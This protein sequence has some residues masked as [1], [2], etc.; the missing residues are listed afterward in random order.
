MKKLLS[1]ISAFLLAGAL[2]V[3][4]AEDEDED[5]V[6]TRFTLGGYSGVIDQNAKTITV[7]AEAS[8]TPSISCGSGTSLLTSLGDISSEDSPVLIKVGTKSQ[9]VTYSVIFKTIGDRIDRGT[10]YFTELYN[11]ASFNYK[12]TNNQFVEISNVSDEELDLSDVYLNRH[13]WKEGKRRSDLDQSVPLTGIKLASKKALVI[14]SQRCSWFTEKSTDTAV[15]KSDFSYNG[16]ISFSDQD[17]FTIT[18]KGTV[19]DSLGPNDGAGNGVNWIAEK[20]MQR[21][22]NTYFGN[23]KFDESQWILSY[24]TNADGDA[25]ATAGERLPKKNTTSYKPSEA[26]KCLTYVRFESTNDY[27][28]VEINES[29]H[30]VTVTF[31][32]SGASYIQ[33]PTV[34]HDGNAIFLYKN[35]G[36]YKSLV[37]GETPVDFSEE[38]LQFCVS[39]TDETE[40]LYDITASTDEYNMTSNISG[41][42]QKVAFDEIADGDVILF[43]NPKNESLIGTPSG[44]TLQAVSESLEDTLT[45]MGSMAAFCVNKREEYYVFTFNGK[46]LASTANSSLSLVGVPSDDAKWTISAGSA[47]GTKLIKNK[48]GRAIEYYKS[49]FGSYSG[50]G[51]AYDIV[52]YK[53]LK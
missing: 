53:R 14:Y 34:S 38:G 32:T 52:F 48:S 26:G 8:G 42:Y 5:A 25:K 3:S 41:T 46:F 45:Y 35:G 1:I 16:I 47:D 40:Q 4:C 11:G 24:A 39:S 37:S 18:Y 21:K 31:Y 7:S 44:T 17:T 10:L 51:D 20:Q 23:A 29:K 13:V 43:A 15:F 12:S 9:T 49:A 6:I 22:D 28:K 33:C 2:F 30:T 19:I 36:F 27:N 50:S